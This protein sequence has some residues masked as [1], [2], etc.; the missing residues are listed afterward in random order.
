M[1]VFISN[2]LLNG[3]DD[4]SPDGYWRS[5]QNENVIVLELIVYLPNNEQVRFTS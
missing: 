5:N 2:W 3:S 4:F 1:T